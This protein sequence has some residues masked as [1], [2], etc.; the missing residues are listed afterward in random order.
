MTGPLAEVLAAGAA[1]LGVPLAAGE[2]ETL[3]AYV[4]LLEKWSRAYNLTAVAGLEA[5]VVLHLLD[6]LAIGPYLRGDRCL[7]VATGA[8]LPGLVLAIADPG[9][10]WTV[11]DSSGK[12]TRFCRQA[13]IELG[14]TSVEVVQARVEDFHPER[15]FD[16]V[17]ARAWSRL[18]EVL[19]K[20]TRLVRPGGR[21]LL[22]KGTHPA[23]ELADLTHPPGAV[24]VHRLEVPGLAAARHLVVVEVDAAAGPDRSRGLAAGSP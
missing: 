24:S 5:M 20:V 18:D 4:R 21:I 15:P 22:M 8:G 2:V 3:L 10:R 13:V 6:S 9:R 12:K 1:A 14:L 16:A 7:D 11:L 19:G 17:T 23:A